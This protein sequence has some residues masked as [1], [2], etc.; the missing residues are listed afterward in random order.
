[1]RKRFCVLALAVLYWC[2]GHILGATP[3]DAAAK[4]PTVAIVFL[5]SYEYQQRDYYEIAAETLHKRFPETKYK[6]VIG[7][8]PQHVFNRYSD[9]NGLTPGEIPPEEKL[10]DFAWSHSFDRVLFLLMTAPNIK[11]NEITIQWENAEVTLTARALAF[12]S[13]QRLKL[14]DVLTT[15][16]A[17]MYHRSAAKKAV[18]QKALEALRDQIKLS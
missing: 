4:T 1:M 6:L 7:E 15:Q 17:L 16:T 2:V 3:V 13:R 11:S 12:D 9:K 18:F 10:I 5:G 14:T 8:H